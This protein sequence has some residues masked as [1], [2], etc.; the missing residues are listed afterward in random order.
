M[1]AET[2]VR[3]AWHPAPPQSDQGAVVAV[4]TFDGVHLGHQA[5]LQACARL[6]DEL[7]L[8][9]VAV[10]FHPHPRQVLEPHRAPALLTPLP[11]RLRLLRQHGVGA[12][13]VI[14]FDRALAD[15]EPEAFVRDVLVGR[16]RAR[17]AV[18]G[19]NFGFGRGRRGDARTLQALGAELGLAVRVVPPTE[20]GGQ[21]VSSSAV[22][23]LLEE[24]RAAEAAALL[25][26]P[27]CLEGTVVRGDG[28][29]RRLGYPTANV[30]TDPAQLLPADGVYLATLDQMPAL[31]VVGTRPTFDG[32]GRWLEVHVLEGRWELY[33][34]EVRVELL[35]RLRPVIPFATPEALVAQIEA[36]RRA[37]AA[38]F[39]AQRREPPLQ[40][41]LPL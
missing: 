1:A 36:D 13:A 21:V 10:T 41:S 30:A 6:A 27:Y 29:G 7:G 4:G 33:G 40:R 24:G 3:V 18:V 39:A 38:Y 5:I 20:Q 8:P 11:L 12:V 37:A 34:K 15:M 14:A 9:A 22:R 2:P 19:F 17:G 32:R 23:R 25:G 35:E 28:R 26:R 16:L 31:A